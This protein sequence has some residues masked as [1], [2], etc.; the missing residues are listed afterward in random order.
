MIIESEH[1]FKENLK[2]GINLF[3]GAGFSGL[4]FDK[5]E[6]ALPCG[7][8]LLEA[9]KKEFPRIKPFNNLS[10]AAA[11]LESTE[12][13]KFY[14]FL[15]R[16]L[17]VGS[18][19]KLYESLFNINI[20]NIYSVNIDDLIYKIY[21]NSA[22]H[23]INDS[24]I[25]GANNNPCAIH[26]HPL[27]GTIRYPE[28]GFI[29]SQVKIASAY[30]DH[31]DSWQSLRHSVESSPVIFWGW[32]FNDTD[33]IEAIYKYNDTIVNENINKWILLLKPEDY[34]KEYFKSLNFNI[35]TGTTEELLNYFLA[36]QSP[37]VQSD[38]KKSFKQIPVDWQIP[39]PLT[40][41]SYPI[42][43]FFEGDSPQW[44]YIFFS[45]DSANS[46]L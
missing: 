9:M 27:H 30:S 25:R 15:I 22:E 3:L 41:P 17:T 40:V 10:K 21:E 33:V 16:C 34:E 32:S 7:D 8:P 19:N 11:V 43:N 2:N 23:F 44:S 46:L 36:L 38:Y 13:D 5:E 6:K 28:K 1:I 42:R 37:K 12:K 24:L 39:K 45:T 26:Y 4:A 31:S 14:K 29:F 18:Y 35:I 20:E